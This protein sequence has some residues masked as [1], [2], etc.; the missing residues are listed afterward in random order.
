MWQKVL[1]K[2][3]FRPNNTVGRG[4]EEEKEKKGEKAQIEKLHLLS[5]FLGDRI[6]GS[7]P[8]KKKS[9]SS[10]KEFPVETENMEFQQTPRGRSSP[11]LVI[12]YP[13]GCVV[14]S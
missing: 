2:L 12:F 5:S 7:R 3:D 11:T 9:V 10:C 1:S 8:I 14:V 13:K 4:K 6:G